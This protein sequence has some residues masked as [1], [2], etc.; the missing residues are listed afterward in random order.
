[1]ASVTPTAMHIAAVAILALSASSAA[2]AEDRPQTTFSGLC[3]YPDPVA[4]Y[5]Y[6]TTLV[7]C[8]TAMISANG[9]T[10]TLDFARRSWGPTARF[11]GTM[12]GDRM[13]VSALRLRTGTTVASTGTCQVFRSKDHALSVISC[14]AKA[15]STSVA[16]NFVASR[17]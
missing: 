13:A 3:R 6:E 7:E 17:L 16:V 2:G 1:M 9:E 15:G 4:R 8:D 11:I 10:T 14:L 12:Q 5:R